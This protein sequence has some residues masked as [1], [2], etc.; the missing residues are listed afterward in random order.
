MTSRPTNLPSVE[1]HH[2][3]KQFNMFNVAESFVSLSQMKTAQ[4]L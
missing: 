4:N 3:V 2:H 1:I